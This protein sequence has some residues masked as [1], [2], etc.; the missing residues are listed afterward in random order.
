MGNLVSRLARVNE[1]GESRTSVWNLE[2]G[3]QSV[4]FPLEG[5]R[6]VRDEVGSTALAFNMSRVIS[7]QG[8]AH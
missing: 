6:K 2:D 8:L 5:L 7:K 3:I 4:V 1:E